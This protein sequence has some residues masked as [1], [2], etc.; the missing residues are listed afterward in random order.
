MMKVKQEETGDRRGSGACNHFF[1]QPIPVYQHS[2]SGLLLSLRK[3]AC[4]V[5]A[6]EIEKSTITSAVNECL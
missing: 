2:Q 6:H 1:K 4:S 3:M 5:H